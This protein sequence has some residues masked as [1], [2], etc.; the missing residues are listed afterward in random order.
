MHAFSLMLLGNSHTGVNF[1]VPLL[2]ET[3]DPACDRNC[4]RH[5]TLRRLQ[6]LMQHAA[7][8]AT[9]YF[10]GYLQK[11]QPIGKKELQQ[12]AKHL[13]FLD[14][15]PTKGAEAQQYRRVLQRICGDLEFRCSVRPLTEETMLAGF[16]D[17]EEVT[18]AECIRSFAVIPFVGADWL[19]Q[20][21][22]TTEVR[23]LVKPFK[24]R[25]A[26]LKASDVYGW[27]G[28]DPRIYYLSPWEFTALWDVQRLQPPRGDATDLSTWVN[29]P[30]SEEEPTDGWQFGRDFVWKKKLPDLGRDVVR[31]PHR[32][33]TEAV[34]D[35]YLRRRIAPLVPY[36]TAAP[37][38]KADMSKAE[39]ARILSVYLRPWTLASEDST[40]HVPHL[41]A[42]DCPISD[43][44]QTPRQRCTAKTQL[45]RRCHAAA[46]RD[47]IEHHIVSANARRTIQNFLAAAECS[48]EEAE[49][50]LDTT[51]LAHVDVDTSWVDLTTVQRL[52][53][54]HGFRYSK[55]SEPTV[56][57]IVQQWT[58]DNAG[59]NPIQVRNK[60]VGIP[61]PGQAPT[62]P[63]TQNRPNSNKPPPNVDVS[64]AHFS[65]HTA[66][67]WLHIPSKEAR[68][69]R[70]RA[71]NRPSVCKPFWN[72]ALWSTKKNGRTC[73]SVLSR[74][75]QSC[76]E[77]QEQASHRP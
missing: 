63:T 7:R 38:P 17:G 47:Y 35:H 30:R 66:R 53:A 22:R 67:S 3:H 75:A 56:Q 44:Q 46:W 4:L 29:N 48:P 6:R 41:A 43:I 52:T 65:A 51:K 72:V 42:L 55:R 24:H 10:T 21:D 64:Y 34:A 32:V 28:T 31:L 71:K 57:N 39:Q 60:C 69:D 59:L 70:H 8:K 74:F 73:H 5:G 61:D 26:A 36:P 13:S 23:A 1:R 18:S 12:A 68:L 27:R 14:V 2:P 11:P 58:P 16:W 45:G 54:G 9:Q 33:A 40:A 15:A 77:C 50:S 49:A 62:V 76:M 37:L 25:H 19:A 20:H